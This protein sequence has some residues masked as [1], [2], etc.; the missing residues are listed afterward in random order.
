ML[1]IRVGS[2]FRSFLNFGALEDDGRTRGVHRAE[3]Y[4]V[5]E[6]RGDAVRLLSVLDPRQ[7]LAQ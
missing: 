5:Y 6:V 3:V 1:T 7:N 2:I 4:W